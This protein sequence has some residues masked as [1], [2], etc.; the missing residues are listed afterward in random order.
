MVGGDH[1]VAI[2]AKEALPPGAEL[3]YDYRRARWLALLLWRGA[4]LVLRGSAESLLRYPPATARSAR[5]YDRDNAPEWAKK[6]DTLS[7]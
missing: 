3:L 7:D 1:R 4:T 6:E 5:R 2:M